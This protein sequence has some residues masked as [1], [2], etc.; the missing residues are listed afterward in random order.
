VPV[1]PGIAIAAAGLDCVVPE[2]ST[3]RLFLLEPGSVD[4]RDCDLR[5]ADVTFLLGDH[6]GLPD[7]LR[8]QWLGLGAQRLSVGPVILYTEDTIALVANELDRSATVSDDRT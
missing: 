8:E 7:A 5:H 4:V 3:S 1:R 2:L 6:L